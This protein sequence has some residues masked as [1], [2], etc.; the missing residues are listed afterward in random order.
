[1]YKLLFLKLIFLTLFITGC[2]NPPKPAKTLTEAHQKL[3][4][5]CKEEFQIDVVLN[6]FD[7]TLWIYVPTKESFFDIK[8]SQEGPKTKKVDEFTEKY[9]VNFIDGQFTENTF[10]IQYDISISKNYGKNYGYST[11]FTQQYQKNQRNLLSAI[12]RAYADIE[13]SPTE[14]KYYKKIQGDLEFEDPLK[15]A[16]RKKFVHAY[17]GE[18]VDAPDFLIIVLADI[19]K[20]IETKMIIA[21]EDLKR[22]MSDH[23]FQGEYAKRAIM[24]YPNGDTKII[25]DTTG[26]HLEA[27]DMTWGEFLTRQIIYRTNYKYTRSAFPPRDN[28]AEQ[29]LEIAYNTVNAY[30]FKYFLGITLQNLRDETEQFVLSEHLAKYAPKEK[31]PKG[32]LHTIKFFE[33]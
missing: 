8:A 14:N 30:D 6:P 4:K 23:S 29:L 15:N 16:S 21:F 25:G 9:A 19:T 11:G 5:I 26:E 31:P 33:N 27:Y 10:N 17:I 24:D 32:K 3:I 13:K 7:H 2:G 12:F 18:E 20:G 1:M 28:A 22:A